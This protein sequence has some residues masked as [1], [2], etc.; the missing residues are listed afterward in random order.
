MMAVYR[1]E[2]INYELTQLKATLNKAQ[3]PF[4]PLK[5]SVLRQYYPEPWMRTS[6]DIDVLVQEPD[7]KKTLGIL[8]EK[9]N[10]KIDSQCSHHY[11]LFSDSGVHIELHFTLSESTAKHDEDP[12]LKTVWE[13]CTPDPRQTYCYLMPEALFFYYHI[14]H[15]AKHFQS[16]GCGIRPFLD[17]WVLD[18]RE[19]ADAEGR[20]ALLRE[21][22]VDTFAAASEKLSRVWFEHEM[23]DEVTERME[24]YLL[25]GGVYGT[26]EQ[27]V[28]LQQ[29]REG[30]KLRYAISRIW[31]PYDVLVRRYP[32][33]AGKRLLLPFYE[34]RRWFS[35]LFCGR[36]KRGVLELK[37]NSATT[38][39]DR[40][41]TK[42]LLDSLHLK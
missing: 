14:V 40:N 26:L 39:E 21:G 18:H 12:V 17:I 20:K 36:V 31:Q 29:A 33:L 23:G 9:M 30:S 11:G 8:T 3:I 41:E 2:R 25:G 4:L 19:E 28:S 22:G 34:V 16:G 7:L 27:R 35:L 10:Y 13:R 37:A 6:C 1:Y 24:R 38:Q 5:G 42:K 32:S 15:M